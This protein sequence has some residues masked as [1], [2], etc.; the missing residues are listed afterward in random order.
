MATTNTQPNISVIFKQLAKSAV[1]RG[2]RG[3]VGFIIFDDTNKTFINKTYKTSTEAEKDSALYT[4]E[5]LQFIKDCFLGAPA[6]VT[7]IRIDKT[8]GKITDALVIAKSL[9]LD[10]TGTASDSVTDQAAVATFIKE[11]EL[12]NKQFKGIVFNNSADVK[13]VVNFVNSKVTFT[14]DTRGEKTGNEYIPSLLGV[15]A[16][17]PLSRSATYLK[18]NNL[19]YVV[20]ETD[21]DTSIQAGKLCL[22]NDDIG[23]VKISTAVNSLTTIDTINTEIMSKIEV[24]EIMDLI[25]KDVTT[26]YKNDYVGQFKNKTDYQFLFIGAVNGYFKGLTKED[27]LDGLYENKSEIDIVAQ[28]DAYI[29]SGKTEAETWDDEQVIAKAFKNKMFMIADVKFLEGMENLR[30]AI[31]IF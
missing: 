13:H 12:L 27:V 2:T 23:V 8:L 4:V 16:G 6:S 10:W 26:T 9:K 30:F 19:K 18:L 25:I 28:R 5:N 22:F 1:K 24:V 21:I 20:E 14:D 17:L 7:V 11:Q 31:T 15:F 3:K 29:A